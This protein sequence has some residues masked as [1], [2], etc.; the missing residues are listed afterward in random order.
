MNMRLLINLND[1]CYVFVMKSAGK[2]NRLQL[3]R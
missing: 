2:A 3:S 1:C